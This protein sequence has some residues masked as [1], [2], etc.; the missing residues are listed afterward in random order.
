MAEESGTVQSVWRVFW[1]IKRLKRLD[2]AGVTELSEETALPISTVHN[3][4]D[5]LREIEYVVKD[6]REYRLANRFIH[7]GDYARY[8]GELFSA[9]KSFVDWIVEE[10]G[11]MV[12]LMIEEFGRGIYAISKTG[13]TR[14]QNYSQARRREYLHSTGAGKAILSK[15]PGERVEEIIDDL[16]LPKQTEQTI[17]DR[18]TLLERRRNVRERGYTLNDEENTDGIRAMGMGIEWGSGSVG[19]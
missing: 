19:R 3:Y 2:G 14:L 1:L 8:R 11:E 7:L 6:G 15:L 13:E 16:G 18:A 4:L 5:T 17:T 9:G 12:N 10:T